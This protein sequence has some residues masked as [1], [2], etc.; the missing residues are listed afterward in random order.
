MTSTAPYE[1]SDHNGEALVYP[2]S[3]TDR[4]G[5]VVGLRTFIGADGEPVVQ[6]IVDDPI[7]LRAIVNLTPEQ[8][9]ALR[10]VWPEQGE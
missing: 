7:D 1:T 8:W 9:D 3:V 2:D 6:I 4:D 5:V 10:Y